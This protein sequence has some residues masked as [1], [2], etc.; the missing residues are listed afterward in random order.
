M[1]RLNVQDTKTLANALIRPACF[2]DKLMA[3]MR[4]HLRRVTE[5]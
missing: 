5:Q 4:E 1:L 2:N 3:A